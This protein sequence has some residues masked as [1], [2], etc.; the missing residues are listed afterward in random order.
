MCTI[1]PVDMPTQFHNSIS[2]RVGVGQDHLRGRPNLLG[3]RK[4]LLWGAA[5]LA[6]AQY[7]FKHHNN[8]TGCIWV[9]V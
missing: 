2:A 7:G 6:T 4:L 1:V 9:S 3:C 5:V 8:H